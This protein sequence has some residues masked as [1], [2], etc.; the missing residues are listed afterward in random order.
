M[1]KL[2]HFAPLLAVT[3]LVVILMFEAW[4]IK[5]QLTRREL[6][7]AESS[8]HDVSSRAQ[9]ALAQ[10]YRANDPV[11]VQQVM[12]G[13]RILDR[14]T[15]AYLIG[16]DDRVV[17]ADRLGVDGLAREELPVAIDPALLRKVRSTLQGIVGPDSA[18]IGLIAY[19]PVSLTSSLEKPF[20]KTGV[21]VVNL[22]N[23]QGMAE[24]EQLVFEA[25]KQSLLVVLFLAGMLSLWIHYFI[26]RRVNRVL[27]VGYRYARGDLSARNPDTSADEIGELAAAFNRMADAAAEKQHSLEQSQAQLREL[28]ETLE[29]RVADRTGQLTDEVEER[30]RIEAALRESQNELLTI[31]NVA[32][33][34]IVVST[35][36]GAITKFNHA[37]ERMFGWPEA[38]MLG[39]KVNRLGVAGALMRIQAG[40]PAQGGA[41]APEREVEAL[42]RDGEVFPVGL[43]VSRFKLRNELHYIGIIRDIRERRAAQD[44]VI[45]ARHRLLEAEKMAALGGLVAG[46]AHEVNTPVGVG[47]TAVSHLREELGGFTQRYRAGEM[48]RSD[49]DHLLATSEQSAQIIFDNLN[50]ASELI[51]SFKEIAVDQTGEDVRDIQLADYLGRVLTSLQPRLKNRPLRVSCSVEPADLVVRLQ[52]GGISQIATNLVMNSLTHGFGPGDAGEIGFAVTRVGQGIQLVYHDSGKGMPPEVA[53]RIF[54]PFFTTRRGQGGSGLG[55][56]IVFNLVNQTYGGEIACESAPGKGARFTITI[57][58]CVVGAKIEASGS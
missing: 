34:G 27:E 30:R 3:M 11:G 40:D 29:Q 36:S 49:L 19:Y 28:N 1:I 41:L 39:K 56:H 48:K 52:A 57:P 53:N 17:A 50:R 21:L 5:D 10:R 55:M 43:S 25:L 23:E 8:L 4:Q 7:Y 20:S 24:V 31:L 54:D 44:A 22:H 58:D 14:E 16:P 42:D 45:A 35:A 18:D 12:S 33:D 51:R 47:V 32:P 9:A 38:E 13:I 15:Q 37:A 46:V 6:A 2:R 26:T